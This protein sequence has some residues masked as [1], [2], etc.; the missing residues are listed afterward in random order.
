MDS[1]WH[2]Q[3][4]VVIRVEGHFTEVKAEVADLAEEL[5]LIDEPVGPI[6]PRDVR[7]S[8]KESDPL[9]RVAS[10]DCRRVERISDELS[11][12]Q[13]NDRATDLVDAGLL[14]GTWQW[15][16]LFERQRGRMESFKYR[17]V[18]DGP[19]SESVATLLAAAFPK[20]N[21]SVDGL[22]IIFFSAASGPVILDI[23]VKL[24]ISTCNGLL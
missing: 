19:L 7:V 8:I 11:V 4:V 13:L 6:S 12:V 20:L 2:E 14:V 18:D 10:L 23:P 24:V 1:S 3:L 5:V 22:R 16:A 9:E 17:E 21:G 15:S